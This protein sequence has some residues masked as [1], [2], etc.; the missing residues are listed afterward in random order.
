MMQFMNAT[1]WIKALCDF[2]I[3]IMRLMQLID[4]LVTSDTKCCDRHHLDCSYTEAAGFDCVGFYA[5][6]MRSAI[7]WIFDADFAVKG[8]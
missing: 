6:D 1:G 7:E 2:Q 4:H 3:L 8:I 5:L